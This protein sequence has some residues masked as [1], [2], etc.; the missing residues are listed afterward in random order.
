MIRLLLTYV[1]PLVLPTAIY[2]T[3]VWYARR[4]HDEDSD[5]DLPGLKKGPLFWSLLAG[6]ALTAAGLVTIALTSGVPPDSGT[7]V[8]PRLEDGRI[9]PP[10]FKK[11]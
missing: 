1:L 2:V 3:W 4:H 5:D 8:A 10:H 7:Y 9:M 11:N 6:L